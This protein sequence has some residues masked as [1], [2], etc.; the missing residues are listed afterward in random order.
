MNRGRKKENIFSR[1]NIITICIILAILLILFLA[2]GA[3]F[4]NDK[5]ANNVM[6][7]STD[8]SGMTKDA[9]TKELSVS[10][11][12][13][14]K[15]I[16]INSN[17]L[18]TQFSCEDLSMTINVEDT[19]EKAFSVGKSKNIF[20]NSFDFFALL[21]TRKDVGCTPDV[22]IEVLDELLYTFGASFNGEFKDYEIHIE[23]NVVTISPRTPGQ[24]PDTQKAR[25]QILKSV[26]NGIFKDINVT[27]EKSDSAPLTTDELYQRLCVPPQDA[28]YVYEEDEILVKEHVVGVEV[29]KEELGDAVKLLNNNEYAKIS[30]KTTIPSKTT[31]ALKAKLFN[32]TL[33][34]YS[35][36]YS[37]REVNR[38]SNVALA[39][40]RINGVVIKPG[41]TFSYNDT[42]GDTTIANGFKVAPVFENGK[43]SQGVGGG[44]CQVSSTLYS[45]VLY[46]DLKVV[47]R[48]NHSLTVAYV[49]KGQDST[50]A[51]GIIDF[52]FANNTD[53]PIKILSAA[54]GGT[55]TISIVGTKRD[56]E[57][58]VKLTHNIIST[59]QPIE[60][61]TPDPNLPADIR[62][63]TSTGK[64]G[65]VVDTIKTVY[66]NGVQISSEKIT[67]S[68]YKMLP[69][70]V[71]V[72]TKPADEPVSGKP[73]PMPD[74]NE[75]EVIPSSPAP[76]PSSTATESATEAP[77]DTTSAPT[78]A[79]LARPTPAQQADVLDS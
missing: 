10:N 11:P 22:N 59:T 8:L 73:S 23:E 79:P 64:T 40:S 21:F 4:P 69:T 67:R 1:K 14:G 18:T 52:K 32:A 51:Y 68:S 20:K 58:T 25:N 74:E 71:S 70:E 57:R 65:Y 6:A 53:Y 5:I 66:E 44:I 34:S 30:A 72:G 37:T 9:A 12:F 62:K 27:L 45:A 43:T 35:T 39:A 47:E 63:V 75:A 24:S 36:S 33:S 17:G 50:V 16:S 2:A 55:V 78:K 54:K 13:A 56:T 31:D 15:L 46:A 19:V 38:A 48:R 49:P 76:S 77:L 60:N 41:E 42:I 26:E 7:G 29:Q 28:E 61:E 3:I